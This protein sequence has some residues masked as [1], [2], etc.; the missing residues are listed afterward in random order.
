M[1][2]IVFWGLVMP[3]MLRRL[4]P[5][6]LLEPVVTVAARHPV[7]ALGV[8][9]LGLAIG[10]GLVAASGVVPIKASSGHWPITE[11]LLQFSKRRSIATHSMTIT[12][13]PLGDP[14]LVLR[15]AGHFELGCRP[16]HGAPG[17]ALATIPQ[18][19]TPR[20]PALSERVP[21]WRPRELFYIVKHGL[22]FTGMPAWPAQQRDD[23]VWALVAFL[24]RLPAMDR[25]DYLELVTETPSESAPEIV[26]T[27]C[28]RCHGLDG[29]GRGAFPKLAGQR[30]EYLDRALQAYAGRRRHSG[31]MGPIATSLTA[32]T[33]ADAVRFYASQPAAPGRAVTGPRPARGA[34]IATRGVPERDIPPCAECHGPAGTPKRAAYPR[35][36][37]QYPEYL[38]QQL[39]L[40]QQR[41]RGGSEYVDLMHSFVDRLTAAQIEDVAQYYGGAAGSVTVNVAPLPAP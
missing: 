31:I 1:K 4:L 27:T 13:P 29:A 39:T 17:D 25:A 34:A 8:L 3:A 33:R 16:C 23:E 6:W 18:A 32:S 15:G 14:A 21:L 35:L 20:P 7:V 36:E 9:G 28:A 30:P 26:T 24:L 37:G 10:G 41:R 38:A 19:M 5:R 22:K 2:R 11:W 40:L 12:A